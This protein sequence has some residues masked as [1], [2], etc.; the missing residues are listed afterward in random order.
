MFCR[1]WFFL[2]LIMMP[3]GCKSGVNYPEPPE[4]SHGY[5][6]IMQGAWKFDASFYIPVYFAATMKGSKLRC[7]RNSI[8]QWEVAPRLNWHKWVAEPVDSWY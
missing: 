8:Q 4:E 6:H 2:A 3:A 7:R 1:I 5:V